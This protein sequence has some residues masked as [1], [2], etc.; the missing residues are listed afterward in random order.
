MLR[1]IIAWVRKRFTEETTMGNTNELPNLDGLLQ[2]GAAHTK[3]V[4][5]APEVQEPKPAEVVVL[6][7]PIIEESEEQW[8]ARIH[9]EWFAKEAGLK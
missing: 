5:V 2:A 8:S 9:A 7:D 1:E 6:P 4:E 3:K